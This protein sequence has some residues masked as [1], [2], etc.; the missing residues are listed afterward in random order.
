MKKFVLYL[1]IFMF[2]AALMAA[3][4]KQSTNQAQS[5]GKK[6]GATVKLTFFGNKA[7]ESNVHVI[8][9][10]MMA[11]M[12]EHPNVVISYESLKGRQY[13]ETLDK[14]MANSSGDDI[15]IV[16]HDETIKLKKRGQLANLVDISTIKNYRE[17][18]RQQFTDADGV[19]W[20]PTTISAFGLYC[21]MDLLKEYGQNVPK[22]LKEFR[23][24]CDYFKSK[25]ITP[26]VANN[27]IS[28]KTIITGVSF[29]DSIQNGDN[30]KLIDSLNDGT[31]LFGS[32]VK[33][34][35]RLV[36][37]IINKHYVDPQETLKTMKTSDDL[38]IFAQ[39]RQPFMFTG[40]WAARRLTTDFDAKFKYELHPL[41]LLLNDAF[42][43]SNPD[44]RLA[45]NAKSKHLKEAK[46]FVEYFTN[47]SNIH[48]FADDQCSIS[49]L[50]DNFPSKV[51]EMQPIVSC[52][53][54]GKFVRAT[55]PRLLMPTWG[56]TRVAVEQLL[57]GKTDSEV[58]DMLNNESKKYN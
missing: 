20:L 31:L 43:I 18:I 56:M 44:V 7:D 19:Y 30:D 32:A 13:Y 42:I 3:C 39:G 4:G 49:P 25:G 55:S 35:V 22:N 27:D 38:K 50:E 6:D 1:L 14:R 47:A 37:L 5:L 9:K 40:T 51:Q 52:Y 10:I 54:E 53:N 26:I 28:L 36:S 57:K 11:Y 33:D 8:E 12:K 23:A 58:V 17:G 41:P 21:N 48:E 34:G 45:V 46:D 29:Y 2:S 24:V 16:D 15:F